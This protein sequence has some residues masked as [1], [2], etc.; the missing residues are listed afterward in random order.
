LALLL[1]KLLT[2]APKAPGIVLPLLKGADPST[3][4]LDLVASLQEL[5]A[6]Q[7]AV[8]RKL[9]DL[10]EDELEDVTKGESVAMPAWERDQDIVQV[11][12]EELRALIDTF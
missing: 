10:A 9:R 2:T 1:A 12:V 3:K 6:L 7:L 4:V 8:Q 5:K 11:A